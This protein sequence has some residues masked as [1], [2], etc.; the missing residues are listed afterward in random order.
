VL[1][2]RLPNLPLVDAGRNFEQASPDFKFAAAVAGFALQLR[3][4]PIAQ[5]IS[6]A[7]V[8]DW[9]RPDIGSDPGG[10][11]REFVELVDR[12]AKIN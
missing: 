9:A 10:Y 4:L 7:V 6:C 5:H 2:A 3:Q 11:R 12:A 8:T 1:L